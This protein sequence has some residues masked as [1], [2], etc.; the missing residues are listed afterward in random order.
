[1]FIVQLFFCVWAQFNLALFRRFRY[2]HIWNMHMLS[3]K[4][5]SFN[6]RLFLCCALLRYT[7]WPEVQIILVRFW[8]N[9]NVITLFKLHITSKCKISV[10][11]LSECEY[12][13]KAYTKSRLEKMCLFSFF[14]IVLWNLLKF[15]SSWKSLFFRTQEFLKCNLSVCLVPL[16]AL[17]F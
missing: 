5:E 1:M 13:F 11:I 3:F 16:F 10:Y 15:Q 12:H 9:Q 2:I 8:I 6:V 17:Y 14:W 4:L 7:F